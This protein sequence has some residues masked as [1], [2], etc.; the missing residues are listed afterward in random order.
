MS[1]GGDPS[2]GL[3]TATRR[4]CDTHT[5]RVGSE[6]RRRRIVSDVPRDSWC[7]DAPSAPMSATDST[8]PQKGRA[9]Q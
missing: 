5:V 2:A 8:Q 6:A 9:S 4:G 3:V 1:S 7:A